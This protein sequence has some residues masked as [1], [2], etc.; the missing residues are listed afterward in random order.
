M[1]LEACAF[2]KG[3]WREKGILALPSCSLL[4]PCLPVSPPSCLETDFYMA[5]TNLLFATQQRVTLNSVFLPTPP[6]NTAEI[7]G[8]H[9][10]S[11]L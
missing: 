1:E 11:C 4:S 3:M 5:Q 9:R 8:V 7:I 10:H 6:P 2:F